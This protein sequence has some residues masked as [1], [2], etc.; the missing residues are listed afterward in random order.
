MAGHGQHSLHG[1]G[2]QLHASCN[3]CVDATSETGKQMLLRQR[4]AP[5]YQQFLLPKILCKIFEQWSRFYSVAGRTHQGIGQWKEGS[6][7]L[8]NRDIYCICLTR[9][10]PLLFSSWERGDLAQLVIWFQISCGSV[11]FCFRFYASFVFWAGQGEP[12]VSVLRLRKK[13]TDLSLTTP[14]HICR[15]RGKCPWPSMSPQKLEIL[16]F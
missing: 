16:L 1:A 11:L 4:T 12:T 10:L 13:C 15:T 2:P 7:F 8:C 3:A 9:L 14:A 6:I 5:R